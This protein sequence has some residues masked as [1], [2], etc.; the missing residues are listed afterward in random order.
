MA[1]FSRKR[2]LLC[3]AVLVPVATVYLALTLCPH[4]PQVGPDWTPQ[5]LRDELERAGVVYEG[6]EMRRAPGVNPGYY[7]RRPGDPRS[8]EELAAH[9]RGYPATMRGYVAVTVM[10][11]GFDPIGHEVEGRVQVG[12]LVLHGDPEEIRRI[13]AALR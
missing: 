8:W 11:A 6:R 5:R 4:G 13:V 3:A 10:P 7:L 1:M 12:H 2:L 9:P